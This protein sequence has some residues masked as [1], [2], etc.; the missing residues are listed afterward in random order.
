MWTLT[1]A[2]RFNYISNLGIGRLDE[3]LPSFVNVI[4]YSYVYPRLILKFFL[5]SRVS[6]YCEQPRYNRN[7][8][9]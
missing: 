9:K 5:N 8:T 2:A 6:K 1:A 7:L 3:F 4:H